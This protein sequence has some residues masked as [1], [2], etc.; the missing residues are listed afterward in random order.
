MDVESFLF[1]LK[2]YCDTLSS[3]ILIALRQNE[4]VIFIIANSRGVA[5]SPLNQPLSASH[6]NF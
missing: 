5:Q 2:K 4:G 3:S 1:V 6:S